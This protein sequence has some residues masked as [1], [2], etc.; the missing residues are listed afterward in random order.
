[1][2]K[3]INEQIAD[4]CSKIRDLLTKKNEAYGNSAL[5]PLRIFSKAGFIE[6]IK[7]RIDDKL[8]RLYRGT[9]QDLVP[10]DTLQDLIGYLI[11]LQIA[12]DT[13]NVIQESIHKP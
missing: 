13:L 8:S 10:E 2:V 11:L 1:M 3:T 6:Q 12:Q 5:N 4:K 9:N 7:V